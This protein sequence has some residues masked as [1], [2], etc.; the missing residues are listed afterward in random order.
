MPLAA[1]SAI[2]KRFLDRRFNATAVKR[3]L[4]VSEVPGSSR[5]EGV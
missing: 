2:V 1:S 4:R 3:P 5:F